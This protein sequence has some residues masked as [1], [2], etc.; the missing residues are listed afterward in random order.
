MKTYSYILSW[1]IVAMFTFSASAMSGSSLQQGSLLNGDS[2]KSYDVIHDGGP[3]VLSVGAY[4]ANQKRG[5]DANGTVSDWEISHMIAYLGLDLTSWLTVIGGAG[6]SD[7]S[8]QGDTRDSDFEWL[9]GIQVRFLNYMVLDPL[10]GDNAYW[11]SIDT[12][13]H[14]I[15]STSEGI[16]S[17][18]TWLEIFG[19]LTMSMTIDTERGGLLDRISIF[20]GPAYSS[21]T[22]TDSDGFSADMNED[23]ATGFVGGI[24]IDPSENVTLRLEFQQFDSSSVGGSLTFHF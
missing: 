2:A 14:S 18:V 22:A 19:S 9:G 8:I 7:L 11:V 20:A 4:V 3:R 10:F 17:D 5:M 13:I 15:G 6:Q 21:I 1:L 12:D 23:Q 24:Q 16:N